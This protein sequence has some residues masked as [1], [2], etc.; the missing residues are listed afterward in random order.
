[1][2][3]TL[4]ELR[5]RFADIDAADL[6][7]WIENRWVRPDE[8]SGIFLFQE[9]DIARV[10]LIAELRDD[11]AVAEDVVPLVLSLLD[12]LYGV[13]RQMRLMCEVIAGQPE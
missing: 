12:Q 9:I 8:V 7:R 6:D 13:R 2:R 1:M 11:L 10:H 5:R 3:V 4:E